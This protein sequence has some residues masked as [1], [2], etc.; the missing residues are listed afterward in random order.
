MTGQVPCDPHDAPAPGDRRSAGNRPP[1]VLCLGEGMVLFA[2]VG[3][4][5][6]EPGT[7]LEVS[8]AGA[9]ANVA[10]GMAQLGHDVEWY[11]RVGQDP[12]GS[13]ILTFL[14]SRGVV[15]DG[16]VRDP[17]RPTGVF[18]KS[19]TAGRTAVY[20]YRRGSAAAELAPSD[21]QNLGLG[22]RRL[23]HVSGINAA[24]STSCDALMECLLGHR[25]P[26]RRPGHAAAHP[27]GTTISFDVNYRPGLWSV[28]EAAP[29]LLHL[30]RGADIVFVG[31]DE[32]MTL[33]GTATAGAIR[34]LLP[35]VPELVVKDADVGAT[36]ISSATSV[37]VPAL[38]VDVVDPVGAGD[39]FAAGFLSARLHGADVTE[40]LRLGHALAAVVLQSHSDLPSLPPLQRIRDFISV[41]ADAWSGAHAADLVADN[42]TEIPHGH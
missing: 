39:A 42:T 8:V 37:F 15:T 36:C 4:D 38:A 41:G 30:A 7:R 14:R 6:T 26:D 20:Y 22:A 5:L 24:L 9:E 17:E 3:G 18:F 23:L 13:R 29:R 31:R 12:F 35:E 40:G 10:A 28:D 33:W 16:V 19:Q 34:E 21:V 1:E 32:A 25:E 11:S 27:G 2:G